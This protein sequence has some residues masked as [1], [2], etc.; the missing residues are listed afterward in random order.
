MNMSPSKHPLQ[1]L[2]RARQIH[3]TPHDL[4]ETE[5]QYLSPYFNS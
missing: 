4:W 1:L 5:E 3:F 2:R